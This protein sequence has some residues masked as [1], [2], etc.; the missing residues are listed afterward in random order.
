MHAASPEQQAVIDAVRSGA[1]VVVDAVAGSGKTT[2]VMQMAAQLSDKQLLQLTYNRHL[3]DDVARRVADSALTNLAVFT[4]HGCATRYFSAGR[5]IYNDTSMCKLLQ[6]AD[7]PAARAALSAI[8]ILVI[9]EAQD[10]DDLLFQFTKLLRRHMRPDL[11]IVA[12]GD[13]WQGIYE[14]KGAD[15]RFLTLSPE[16]WGVP[17][18]RLKLSTSYRL[19]RPMA[20]FVNQ[21]MLSEDRLQVVKAGP[22][23]R[24]FI[25]KPFQWQQQVGKLIADA[26]EA[27]KYK[28]DDFFVLAA[29][30]KSARSP[31]KSLENWLVENNVPCY[32]PNHD[33]GDSSKDVQA[34]KVVFSS[35]HQSKGRERKVVIVIG[36][37]ETYFDFYARNAHKEDC[38]NPLYVAASRATWQMIIVQT[39][40]PAPFIHSVA[41]Q[42]LQRSGAL[43][44]VDLRFGESF[45]PVKQSNDLRAWNVT[46][47]MK[48]IRP[49]F[50]LPLVDLV[51]DLFDELLPPGELALDTPVQIQNPDKGTYEEV[52]D[53]IGVAIPALL[54]HHRRGTCTVWERLLDTPMGKGMSPVL[55]RHLKAA[56]ATEPKS[57]E[58]MLYAC[59][60]YLARENEYIHRLEQLHSYD[61]LLE[62]DIATCHAFLD[63]KAG[64]ILAYE[65]PM[66]RNTPWAQIVGVLDAVTKDCVFEFKVTSELSF[67]HKLQVIVY[68]WL[69]VDAPQKDFKLL[70]FKTGQILALRHDQAAIDRVVDLL[71]QNKLAEGKTLSDDDFIA[72]HKNV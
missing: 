72:R 27:G 13:R 60:V 71:C 12:M 23:I 64:E 49:E 63:A 40:K 31:A 17:F 5:A 9:D 54:E 41:M 8:D 53:I 4:F 26:I 65:H 69:C 42:E 2:T 25:S 19:T 45:V 7:F 37:D 51:D 18:T 61:W 22:P 57:V 52:A 15:P 47:L 62:S 34:D 35:F 66:G 46:D 58:E 6:Q 20:A 38:P 44:V 59:T 39:H 70:N 43:D 10:L 68:A 67:E 29:S 11:R 50:M 1:N 30:V 16:L 55:R 33:Q 14:V 32:A 24:Y 21:A 36:L 3:K 48:F 28:P 56:Q